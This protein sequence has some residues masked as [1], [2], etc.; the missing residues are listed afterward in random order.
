[1]YLP[2]FDYYAPASLPEACALL[3]QSG[4]RAKV[5]AGGTDVLPMM[6][7]EKIAP[8][9]LVS[10]KKLH[11]LTGIRE[12]PGNKVV[13]GARTTHNELVN[14]P[15]LQKKYLSVCVAAHRIGNNQIRNVGTIGGNIVN[16]VP[17]ADLPP[18]LIALGALI[19]LTGT[20]GER[21]LPLEEAFA[22]P[23]RS[24]ISPDEILTAVIIP[25][26]SLTG[27]T[28]FKFAHRRSGALAVVGVAAAV[29]MEGEVC[30]EARIA[31]GA[32]APTPMRAKKAEEL[33]RGRVVTEELLEEAGR[34]AAAES[35]TRTSIRGSAD[36]RRDMVRVFTKRAL[37]K[38]IKD[39]H[40]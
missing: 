17:S 10:I 18:I 30:R 23:G 16:A 38:A 9:I 28:Y 36:Y 20:G 40:S 13:I 14:S 4:P 35:K 19:K 34:C 1:M 24:A 26:S 31:L 32:A 5:L 27:S 7:K 12:T 22:G 15:V 21:D 2:D 6:K 3:A 25:G 33:L 29:T 39:G 8:E 11:Q 37:R